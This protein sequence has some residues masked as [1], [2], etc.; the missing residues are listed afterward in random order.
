MQFIDL[1]AQ[2]NQKS[3]GG[4]TFKEDIEKHINKVI[5]HGR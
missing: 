4:I 5:E 2:Q 1:K 3:R